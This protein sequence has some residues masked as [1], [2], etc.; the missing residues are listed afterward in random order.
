M[1]EECCGPPLPPPGQRPPDPHERTTPPQANPSLLRSVR[2]LWFAIPAALALVLGLVAETVGA[3]QL[4]TAATVLALVLGGSTFVPGALR[5]LIAG[6]LGVGLLM[7]IGAAGAVL[8]GELTEAAM[9]AVLFSGSEALEELS[10]K[11]ARR[12]LRSLLSLVPDQVT[13]ERSGRDE[14]IPAAHLQPG[15]VLIV[16]PGERLATDGTVRAGRSTLDLAA[17]TGESLPVPAG[18]GDA[19]PA[20]AVNGPGVLEV[21]AEEAVASNS[22]ARIVAVVEAEQAR[23]GATQRLADRVARPMV[24][25]VLVL[26]AAIAVAGA[27][28][29]DPAVWLPRALVVVVAA[30]PCALA[31]SVPVT[32]IAAI[33]AASRL[34]A[35]VK[36]GA[37]LEQLATS[38]VIAL[39]KTGTITAGAPSVVDVIPAG[40]TTRREVLAIAGALEARSEHPLAG[41]VV[42]AS[43][44]PAPAQDTEA[45]PGAGISGVL[46]GVHVRAGRPGWIP[47]DGLAEPI[48]R[49]EASGAT[50]IVVE[51]DGLPVGAIGLRDEPRPEARTVVG[52]LRARGIAAVML[53]GDNPRTA[54]TIARS[55]SI[56]EI[57]AGLRPVD[58]ADMVRDL[59]TRGRVAMVG[60]GINDAPALAASDVGI[61]MAARGTDVA[62]EAA[63]VALM[64]EDLRHLPR[65][66]DHARRSYSIMSQN[67]A[68]SILIVAVL[69]PL[70]IAGTLGLAAVVAIHEIAEM[71]VI[72]N[73]IRAGRTRGLPPLTPITEPT[74][75]PIAVP[76]P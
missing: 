20:G 11:R 16:R 32:S 48:R 38:S 63:D 33:G 41:A 14:V 55:V 30:S 7:T 15:D 75:R 9:L 18:V 42:A 1:S 45:A 57:H 65:L 71:A 66:I 70:A 61:A 19:V 54:E 24:P 3:E 22:L 28:L 26:A 2:D 58:K 40:G 72:A 6:R 29:G 73:G 23:K 56:D 8:L 46:D 49:L 27:I 60:D 39:D 44:H 5:G 59:R 47:A 36:G 37:A 12:G 13:I 62:I 52:D 10:M 50:V 21:L 43:G 17:I 34:G 76:T 74:G 51:R 67:L 35:L 68:L 31:I 25:G 69:L 64:G 4:G 53:T